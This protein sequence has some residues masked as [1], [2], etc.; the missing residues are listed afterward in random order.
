MLRSSLTWLLRLASLPIFLLVWEIAASSGIV[1]QLLFPPPS[2]VFQSAYRWVFDGPFL[3]DFTAS[4]RR[5]LIGFLIGAT[6]GSFIGL[7]T[8]SNTYASALLSPVF[9]LLRPIPPIAFVPLVVLWFGLG[10]G[11]KYFLIFWGVFFT[12]WMSSHIGVQSINETYLRVGR[13]LG[14]SSR[15]MFHHILLPASLPYILVGMR[16][17]VSVSFYALVAAEIAGANSGLFYR[18]DISQTNMQIGTA[19][20]GLLALGLI[21]LIADKTFQLIS[22]R[23]LWKE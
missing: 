9:A 19:M 1:N 2:E 22:D 16:T 7:L 6:V 13:C 10:E 4:A 11:G 20:A 18:V 5:V 8:G 23:L 21:S 3:I 15:D 14:A 17:A 12:V